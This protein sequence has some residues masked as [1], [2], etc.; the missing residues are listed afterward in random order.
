MS[1][2]GDS[3]Q[4]PGPSPSADRVR[5]LTLGVLVVAYLGVSVIAY[6][7]YP[8]RQEHTPLADLERAGLNVWRKYNCQ[9]CHQIHGFGGFLGPD[10]TNRVTH[11][12]PD[13]AFDYLLMKGVGR[14]PALWLEPE[15]RQAVMAYLRALNRTG[16]ATPKPLGGR[17]AINAWEHFRMIGEEW[18]RETGKSLPPSVER[19]LDIVTKMQ[20]GACHVPFMTG[21]HL[22]PDLSLWATT[23]APEALAKVLENGKGR[24][25]AFRMQPSEV[26]DVAAWL[27]WM[28][29]ERAA[30]VRLN[31]RLIEREDFSWTDV[32]W[33]EYEE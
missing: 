32:P 18:R 27:H 31:G 4:A 28:H 3:S 23:R 19:G 5:V 14:M 25:P 7:D 12:T 15:E 6:T 17:K 8:R 22:S 24:M 9:A 30:L 16:R 11:D 2:V 29:R 33:F 1:Y 10:L 21:R 13:D 26:A 20:C